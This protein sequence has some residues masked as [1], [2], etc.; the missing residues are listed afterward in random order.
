MK[1][2]QI[3]KL[4]FLLPLLVICI[5]LFQSCGGEKVTMAE[6]ETKYGIMKV[7]LYNDTPKHRDNFIKLANEGFYDGTLFHRVMK[8]FMI[9]GG[10]PNSIGA[11]AGKMLG[12]GGPGYTLDAEIGRPH[13]KGALSAARLGDSQNPEKKSSGSQFFI[14]QGTLQNPAKV[15]STT[16]FKKI[17]YPE[18][19][20]KLYEEIG[21]TPNLD[22]DYTVFGEVVEGIEI[23]DKIAE[24]STNPQN[25]PDSDIDMKVRIIN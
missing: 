13:L 19:T 3:K 9:Q 23:I 5:L 22:M 14:V 17:N 8:N 11:P 18:E 10:D 15:K 2:N 21:G 12:Q 20:L 7:K 6:I 1:K 16:M 4:L 24:E 25:R